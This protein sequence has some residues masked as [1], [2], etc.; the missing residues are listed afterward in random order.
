M[1]SYLIWKAAHIVSACVLFGGGIGIAFFC[2]FGARAALAKNDIASLRL[3]LKFTVM[4]DTFLT[5]PAV[6]FQFVSGL[7]LI[8]LL[9]WAWNS[10]WALIV[11]VLFAFVGACWLPVVWIQ[12]QLLRLAD[13]AATTSELPLAFAR[14]FRLWFLLGMPAFASVI[15]LIYIMVAKPFAVR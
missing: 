15:A 10:T 11:I 9:D 8:H 1:D 12:I 7:W 2:W 14:W 13:A 3:V 5:A 6:V 4:A